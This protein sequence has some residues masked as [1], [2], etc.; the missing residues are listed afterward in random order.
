MKLTE[1]I[2]SCSTLALV[3]VFS[4]YKAPTDDVVGMYLAVQHIFDKPLS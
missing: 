4:V 2:I 3:S 1:L